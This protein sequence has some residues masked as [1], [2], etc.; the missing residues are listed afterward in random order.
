MI[1]KICSKLIDITSKKFKEKYEQYYYGKLRKMLKNKDFSLFSPNCYAGIIYHR[2]G[3]EFKSP[4]INMFFP[5]KKQY[6][7]FVSN[8]KEYLE[9]KL[10]F[11]QDEK[12]KCPVAMLGDVKIVF[13]HDKDKEVILKNWK[14]RKQRVNYNNIF[15]LLDDIAD[16]EYGDL[17]KFNQIQCAGKVIFSANTYENIDNV[18]QIS[19]YKK[20]G[21]LKP[22]LLEKS[23]WTGKN[24][25][26]K[27]FDFVSWLNRV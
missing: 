8:I 9:Y 7:K 24:P 23:K 15:I 27:D 2:L 18:I 1:T 12:Y 19:K 16:I 17:V 14:R 13:N 11:I 20:Y 5:V 10:V 22:Y 3:L 21:T 6:L 25:A 4:T 26:D